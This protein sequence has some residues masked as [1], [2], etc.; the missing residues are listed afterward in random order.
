MASAPSIPG[1]TR[2]P[3]SVSIAR[4]GRCATPGSNYPAIA[5][6]ACSWPMRRT[7]SR[8][9]TTTAAPSTRPRRWARP[10]S[11]WSSA[12]CRNIRG[13]EVRRP[14][15]SPARGRRSMMPSPKCLNT[16]RLPSMPLAIEPLHPAYAADRACVNTTKQALDI[17][18]AL[19][20]EAQRHARRRARRLSHLVGSGAAAADRAGRQGTPAGVSRLRLAGADQRHPQRPRHDGRRRHRHQIGAQRRSRRRALPAIPRSRFFRTTGGASR[21]TRSCRPA[22]S[23]TGRWCR[24]LSV[25]VESEPGSLFLDAFSLREPVPVSL[26]PRRGTPSNKCIKFV[27]CDAF[28]VPMKSDVVSQSNC[29][30]QLIA[31]GGERGH[32]ISGSRFNLF[33]GY[34]A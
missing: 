28:A 31:S 20:P 9:A 29:A 30:C 16:R 17:C 25:L 13:R 34:S 18:D 11:C 7:G 4:C 12:A 15:T 26:G 5:A 10:A 3:P 14:G 2:S 23:G 19:D 22:S 27:Q 24:A 6:A 21:W 33:R 8:R 32:S 1:A